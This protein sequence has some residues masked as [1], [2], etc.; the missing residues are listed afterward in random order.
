VLSDGTK[1]WLNSL[2]SI[3]FLTAFNGEERI[4]DITGEAYFEVAKNIS[5][6]FKV[7]VNG[8]Q[9]E[10]L[11]GHINMNS[12]DDETAIKPTLQEE[13]VKIFAGQK[14]SF[15]KPGQQ[16]GLNKNGEIKIVNDEDRD[17]VVAWKNGMFKFNGADIN[18]IMR[19]VSRWYD[20]DV[21]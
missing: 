12:Y 17:K 8:V 19:Q 16:A 1:V 2:S 6:P 10:V 4:V 20:E 13:T 15:L 7:K 11:G 18:T 21:A 14:I 5:M 9:V 3:H